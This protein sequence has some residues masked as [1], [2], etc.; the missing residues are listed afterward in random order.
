MNIVEAI[1]LFS[2]KCKELGGKFDGDSVSDFLQAYCTLDSP[3]KAR[4]MIESA[5]RI[6]KAWERITTGFKKISERTLID[7]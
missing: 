6:W 3:E 4:I 1:D 7:I 5:K 2:K